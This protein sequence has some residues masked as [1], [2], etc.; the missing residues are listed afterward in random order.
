M[1]STR[2]LHDESGAAFVEFVIVVPLFLVMVFALI[3]FGMLFSLRQTLSQAATEGARAAAIAPFPSDLT[4]RTNR[5]TASINDAFTG[6]ASCGSGLTCTVVMTPASCTVA[7]SQCEVAVTLTYANLSN[8]IP[9][10]QGIGLG[11]PNS[12][13]YKASARIK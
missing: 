5:A 1:K 8:R 7:V 12:L 2:R 13:T 10:P 4:A 9:V 3:G 6:D 11:F